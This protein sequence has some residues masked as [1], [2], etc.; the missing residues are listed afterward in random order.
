MLDSWKLLTTNMK[1]TYL[2]L[3]SINLDVNYL[4]SIMKVNWQRIQQ[5]FSYV[6]FN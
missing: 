5:Q 2:F 1:S 6:R 3:L 4:Y